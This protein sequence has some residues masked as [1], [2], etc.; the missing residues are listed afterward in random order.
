MVSEDTD[1]GRELTG[2]SLMFIPQARRAESI[3]GYFK[4]SNSRFPELI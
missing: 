1:H 4:S 3:I 2:N